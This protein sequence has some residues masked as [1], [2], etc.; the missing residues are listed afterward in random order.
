[1]Y[2][3]IWTGANGRRHRQILSSDR[4]VAERALAKIVRERDLE[5]LGLM[6]EEGQHRWLEEIRDRYVTDME[7]WA[8]AGHLRRVRGTLKRL[9]ADLGPMRVIDLKKER[10]LTSR[11]KRIEQGKANRTINVELGTLRA[12]LNWGVEVGLIGRNP[13]ANLKPL[14]SGK[15][16]ERRPR[17]ALSRDEMQ[18]LLEAAESIDEHLRAYHG[19][20]KSLAD[21]SRGRAFKEKRRRPHVPQGPLWK[22]FLYTGARWSE[23]TSTRWADFDERERTLTLRPETTKSKKARTIPLVETASDDLMRLRDI[24]TTLNGREPKASEHVFLGPRGKPVINSY[25]RAL[26]R[27]RELLTEASIPEVDDLDRRID[28]HSLRHSFASALN[29]A[30]VGLT[31]AQALLGHSDPKLTASLYTHLGAEDLRWAVEK[32]D[33]R[34]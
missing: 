8:S 32:L 26:Y 16:Y 21:G 29:R 19:A 4:R 24:H 20:E 12:M 34:V 7:T 30:S 17:R 3:G 2:F 14:P 33:M 13:I 27:F 11:Q 15:A 22:A 31:Q 18:Q 10:L 1:V 25:R 28:I 9:L 6:D 23:L 5:V